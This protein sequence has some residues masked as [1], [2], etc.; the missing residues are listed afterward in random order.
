M[1]IYERTYFISKIIFWILYLTSIL[2]IWSKSPE[3]LNMFNEILTIFIG[4]IL[5][6]LFNPVYKNKMTSFHKVI[7]F[8]AGILI[9]FTSS[10]KNILLNIP[11]I[12]KKYLP[13]LKLSIIPILEKLA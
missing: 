1:K 10:F 12:E 2:N 7:A 4:G 13:F 6:Y 5:V 9:L 8:D 11:L 3:Y